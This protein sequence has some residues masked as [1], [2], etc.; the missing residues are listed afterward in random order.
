MTGY[1]RS[2]VAG[3]GLT[4]TVDIQALNSRYLDLNIRLPRV[5]QKF[6]PEARQLTREALTRGKI[7]IMVSYQDDSRSGS[8]PLLNEALLKQYQR[9]FKQ[10]SAALSLNE[11]A[12]LSDYLSVHDLITSAE[13]DPSSD[14]QVLLFE[15]L[16]D[17]LD[18]V[19]RM[20]RE[21]GDNLAADMGS[22][23]K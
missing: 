23:L 5:L 2:E 12:R 20:R 7:A 21:E 19:T 1:G 10:M 15:A 8:A 9:L 13:S 16:K 4:V 11:E 22:R 17:A 3:Q 14:L 6:E 18:K